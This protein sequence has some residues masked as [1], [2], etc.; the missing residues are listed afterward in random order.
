MRKGRERN[1][2]GLDP[3]NIWNGLTPISDR[4]FVDVVVIVVSL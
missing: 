2:E 3:H 4:A 1:F